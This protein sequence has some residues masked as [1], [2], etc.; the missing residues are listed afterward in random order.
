LREAGTLQA[1][2]AEKKGDFLK[3]SLRKSPPWFLT[4]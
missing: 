2:F 4:N 1:S 3:F